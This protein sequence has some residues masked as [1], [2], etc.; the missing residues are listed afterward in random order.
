MTKIRNRF[1]I[2]PVWSIIS[3]C[4]SLIA[5]SI[6]DSIFGG[7]KIPILS[8][9]ILLI[10]GTILII[11]GLIILIKAII[12]FNKAYG[13]KKLKTNGLYGIFR[14]PLYA[15]I[16]ILIVPGCIFIFNKLFGLTVPIVMYISFRLLIGKEEKLLINEFG[17]EYIKYKKNVNAIFP[18]LNFKLTKKTPSS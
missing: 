16:T 17:N 13:Q 6:N 14:H 1:G 2:G 11:L 8:D 18:K 9:N 5:I 4:Y 3:I 7:Q 12:D 10:I 15:S